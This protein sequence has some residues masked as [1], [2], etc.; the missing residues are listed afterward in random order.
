VGFEDIATYYWVVGTDLQ[1]ATWY[2]L[3]VDIHIDL[4]YT[5]APLSLSFTS[6]AMAQAIMYNWND[7]F[8]YY[9]I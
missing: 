2:K 9:H 6:A 7:G 4:I 1:A 8:E 5:W 3:Q